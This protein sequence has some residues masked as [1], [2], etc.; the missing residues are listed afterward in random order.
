MHKE[1]FEQLIHSWQRID[2]AAIKQRRTRIPSRDSH[3]IELLRQAVAP[4][5]LYGNPR[6]RG[7]HWGCVEEKWARSDARNS[8]IFRL[9]DRYLLGASLSPALSVYL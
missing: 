2:E 3:A 7:S 4:G 8:G 6:P 9:I 5:E 1:P